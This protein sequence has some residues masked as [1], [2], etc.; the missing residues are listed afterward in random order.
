MR[1]EIIC[2]GWNCEQYVAK[3]VQSVLGQKEDF[4]LHLISDGSTDGTANELRKYE[5]RENISVHIYEEN[6][7]AAYRRVQVIRPL[8]DENICILLGMDDEMLPN[9]LT[10]IKREY[11]SGK[12]MTYGNWVGNDGYMLPDGFLH[13]TDQ[14]HAER[15]YRQLTFRSTGLNTFKKFLFNNIPDEDFKVFG[16]WMD[17]ATETELMFSCLEMCGKDRIGI[18]EE[19]IALYNRRRKGGTL[20]R[21]YELNGVK[22]SGKEYKYKILDV[23]IKRPKKEMIKKN[24]NIRLTVGLPCLNSKDIVWLA[25]EGLSRQKTAVKWELIVFEDSQDACGIDYF[26]EWLPKMDNCERLTYVYCDARVSLSYKWRKMSK[27]MDSGSLGLMLQAS[28]C[29]SEPNRINITHKMLSEGYDWIHKLKGYFYNIDTRQMMLFNFKGCVTGLDMAISKEALSNLP[30][31]DKYVSVDRW[32]YNNASKKKGFKIGVTKSKTWNKGVDTDGRNR[33]SMTRRNLYK[34]PID[35]FERTDAKIEDV[36]P[37]EVLEHFKPNKKVKVLNISSN[38]WA[39]YSHANMVSLRSV[40]VQADGLKIHPHSFGYENQIPLATS[41]QI[42]AKIP[43]Y[44]IIQIFNSDILMLQLVK[45]FKGKVLVYHTGTSYREKPQELNN[46]FNPVVWKTCIAHGEFAGKGAKNEVYIDRAVDTDKIKPVYNNLR[47]P[48]KF[49]HCPSSDKVKGTKAISRMME[50]C[51]ANFRYDTNKLKHSQSL[52]R[53][54][55][56]DIYVELF[57]PEVNGKKYGHFGITAIEAA[58]MCKVVVT[59]NL[60]K[61]VYQKYYGDSPLIL[62]EDESDFK[63]KIK[64]L[65]NLDPKALRELQHAHRKWAVEKHSYKAMGNKLKRILEI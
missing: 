47:K 4:H 29:Y 50:E 34:N 16:K 3:C 54:K 61:E 51:G 30:E 32:L 43:N 12:W 45:G 20:N 59:Q 64:W 48:Y 56:C 2:T 24:S 1:F 39:N 41:Q 55:D 37:E 60:S 35:P 53:M 6:L 22:M 27:L 13:F 38:D 44:D 57:S 21:E 36:L 17:N 15:N 28:D 25:M 42:R 52:E 8:S 40:G 10:R 46:Y 65:M 33:I 23:I 11:D 49:L 5:G 63:E 7:G 26:K 62:A 31:Q 58:A 14:E 18:I 19:P 9:C